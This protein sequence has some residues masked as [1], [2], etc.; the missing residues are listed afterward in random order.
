M[1]HVLIKQSK[2]LGDIFFCQKI[3]KIF[4]EK[5]HQVIWPVYDKYFDSI[6]NY[7][8]GPQYCKETSEFVFKSE[9][10]ST[11]MST[12]RE[13][14][15]CIVIATDGCSITDEYSGVMVSKYKLVNIDY[16]DWLLYFNF[17]RNKDQEDKLFHMLGLDQ[18][19]QYIVVNQHIGGPNAESTWKIP[20]PENKKIIEIREIPGFSIF[21]WCKVFEN[22]SEFHTMETCLSYIIEKLQ[23]NELEYK[24]YHRSSSDSPNFKELTTVH[25]K[26]KQHIGCEQILRIS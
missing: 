20:Y 9:Y 1:K 5:G 18:G 13:Y 14:D 17:N 23:T 26:P 10:C 7:I 8:D 25:L 24:M 19:R 3:A 16:K 21:D 22:A 4:M 2:G 15:N 12:I 6:Q 11:P